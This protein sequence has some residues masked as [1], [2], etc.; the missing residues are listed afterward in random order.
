MDAIMVHVL[1]V[2]WQDDEP[3]VVG[4]FSSFERAAMYFART[5]FQDSELK[6]PDL[7]SMVA[8]VALKLAHATD[9]EDF[10]E[11]GCS[12]AWIEEETVDELCTDIEKEVPD[13]YN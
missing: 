12:R 2:Q 1:V 4:V 3:A 10:S 6:G 7:K 9:D 11:F 5:Y 13:D 8:R